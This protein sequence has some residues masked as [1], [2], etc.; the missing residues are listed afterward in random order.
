ME[1][2]RTMGKMERK[3]LRQRGSSQRERVRGSEG[4]ISG[5]RSGLMICLVHRQ[6]REMKIDKRRNCN[7]E[8][9][10]EIKEEELGERAKRLLERMHE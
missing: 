9:E 5:L 3:T 6:T 1:G 2:P 10:R 7:K 8:G 4:K